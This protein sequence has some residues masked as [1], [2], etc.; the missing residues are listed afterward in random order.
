M[1]LVADRDL[2][3][4]LTALDAELR[5]LGAV[6]VELCVIGGAALSAAAADSAGRH[7]TDLLALNPAEPEIRFAVRWIAEQDTLEG[8]RPQLVG[9]LDYL[10]MPHAIDE[11]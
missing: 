11:V 4:L 8:F 2:D 7:L 6:P 10:G 1:A 9:L 3:E 5:R